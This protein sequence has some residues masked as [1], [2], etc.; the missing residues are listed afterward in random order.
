MPRSRSE[1]GRALSG[2]GRWLDAVSTL[3]GAAQAHP[4]SAV[5]WLELA[6]AQ[7]GLGNSAGMTTSLGKVVELDP[8]DAQGAGFLAAMA[9]AQS[10][11]SGKNF[12]QAIAA[13]E[14]AVRMRPED[15]SAWALLGL[16]A[17]ASG[18]LPE[19]AL[20]LE[21][22]LAVAPDRPDIAH[23]LGTVYLAQRRYPEAATAFRR[24]VS[25][26]PGATE[27]AAALSR[28]EAQQSG[29]TKEPAHRS[30][31]APAGAGGEAAGEIPGRLELGARLTA[32]DYPPLG[33]RGLL[34]ESVVS[35]GLAELSGLLV[36]DLVLRAG[37]RPLTQ[38]DALRAMLESSGSIPIQLS[39]LRSG[40]SVEVV[41]RVR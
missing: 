2:A 19:A 11:L 25:L 23:N 20:N 7:R 32:V 30:Q 33:I 40:K 4:E 15:G 24:A 18:R 36:D 3:L 13:A 29:S 38:P 14:A 16:S 27:S 22:A 10:S 1:L 6:F 41:L 8:S 31:V 28:L 35:G 34:V 17:Q 37:G 21:R 26:D 39:V 5:L 9:L 12:G